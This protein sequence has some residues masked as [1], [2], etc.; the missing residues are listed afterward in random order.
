MPMCKQVYELINQSQLTAEYKHNSVESVY[1]YPAKKFQ[2][3]AGKNHY[4]LKRQEA[5][6]HILFTAE[7]Q[8]PALFSL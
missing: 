5:A 1:P 8:N 4:Y 7:D 6:S 2:I 3:H